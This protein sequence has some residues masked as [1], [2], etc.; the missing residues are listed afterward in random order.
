MCP[1]CDAYKNY[2]GRGIDICKDWLDF[3][4]FKNWAL[5]N[6]YQDTLTIDRIDVNGN[7][8]SENCRWVD[9][10]TQNRNTRQNVCITFGGKTQCAADWAD[11]LNIEPARIR[12]RLKRGWSV[13]KALLTPV[14]INKTKGEKNG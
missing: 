8:C 5:Q 14:R 9:R 7:Y 13:E 2:G 3:C 4:C 1:T 6:G 12:E 11:E 10:K